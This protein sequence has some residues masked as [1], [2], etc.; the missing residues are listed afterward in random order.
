MSYDL[1]VFKKESAPKTRTDF[2]KWYK[3]QTEWSE[4]HSYDNPE[5]TS[6]ELRNWFLEM[7]ISFPAMNGPYASDEDN[8]SVTD[9]S[10]GRNVIYA[11]FAW[12][13][14]EKAYETMLV[15]A[16]KHGVGFF[17]VSSENGDIY[18]PDK[19][20]LIAIENA[21][22]KSQNLEPEISSSGQES[23]PWWKFWS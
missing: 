1:M 2:M 13:V 8:A 20:K 17:D 14:A 12:S 19:G 5:N 9:Y 6:T 21:D 11:A 22:N 15:L 16:E 10:I 7:I 23:K 4:E 18:F 3:T